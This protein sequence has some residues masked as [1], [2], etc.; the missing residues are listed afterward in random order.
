M[1]PVLI[2]AHRV[3]GP[4]SR[5]RRR[6]ALAGRLEDH[7]RGRH[8]GIER[9]DGSRHRNGQSCRQHACGCVVR[10]GR[11][12]RCRPR[13]PPD[14]SGRRRRA[15]CHPWH[16]PWPRSRPRRVRQASTIVGN[17]TPSLTGTRKIDPGGGAHGL[18]V[19]RVDRALGEHHPGA[20]GGL[21][22][23]D[24]GAG[25]AGIADRHEH[26]ERASS[27]RGGRH[28]VDR[29]SAGRW[30]GD[31]HEILR[32]HHV[33][34]LAQAT[35]GDLVDGDTRGPGRLALIA[36][37]VSPAGSAYTASSSAPASNASATQHGA[38]DDGTTPSAERELRRL[39]R[40][41]SRLSPGLDGLSGV[42]SPPPPEP[43]RPLTR[44]PG[45][46]PWSA[47]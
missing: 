6:P 43:R 10:S 45:R 2:V 22:G 17:G 15:A 35:V 38:V 27:E 39:D 5:F 12:P 9:L 40:R 34:H 19:E 23:S 20:S 42:S 37:V 41:R 8:G 29:A 26:H 25:V 21:G 4:R 7:D 11:G 47:R 18:R 44:A 32:L 36:A 46:R 31:R 14:R 24:H 13:G 30:P 28:Q 16:R 3:I 1:R 33:E